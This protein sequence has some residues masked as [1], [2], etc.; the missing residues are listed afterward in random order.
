MFK[1]GLQLAKQT[2]AVNLKSLCIGGRLALADLP[3]SA[4]VTTQA[5]FRY[6]DRDGS[7]GG[8]TIPGAQASRFQ[9]EPGSGKTK[10]RRA[11]GHHFLIS[12]PPLAGPNWTHK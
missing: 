4:F 5:V 1:M 6:S 12:S 11:L 9:D 2:L 8:G 10:S 7:I 3:F